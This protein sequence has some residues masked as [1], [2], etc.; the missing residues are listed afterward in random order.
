MEI[1]KL[2]TRY[3]LIIKLF[4]AKKKS[5]QFFLDTVVNLN[6]ELDYNLIIFFKNIFSTVR[7]IKLCNKKTTLRLKLRF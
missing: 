6:F 4:N 1:S 3:L 7:L 2:M 5:K